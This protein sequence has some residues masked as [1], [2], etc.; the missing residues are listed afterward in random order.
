MDDFNLVKVKKIYINKNGK[1]LANIFVKQLII[2][3]CLLNL[4]DTLMVNQ[5]I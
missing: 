2:K 5:L 4:K 1:V 3:E